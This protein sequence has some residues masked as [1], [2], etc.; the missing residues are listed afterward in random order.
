MAA[1]RFSMEPGCGLLAKLNSAKFLSHYKARAFGEIFLLQN[2]C[3]IR[4]C[5]LIGQEQVSVSHINS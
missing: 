2:F 1:R 3:H 4:Y 5:D